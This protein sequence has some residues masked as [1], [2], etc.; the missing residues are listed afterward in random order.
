MNVFARITANERGD[1][2]TQYRQY[3]LS[4]IVGYDNGELKL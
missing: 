4:Y 1:G 2:T 3:Q